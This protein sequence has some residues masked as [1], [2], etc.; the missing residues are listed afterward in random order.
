MHANSSKESMR[1]LR[2]I[3]IIIIMNGEERQSYVVR[4]SIIDAC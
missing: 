4:F 3:I 1:I 2:E